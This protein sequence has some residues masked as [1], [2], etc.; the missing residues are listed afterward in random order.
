MQEQ[1]SKLKP[2]VEFVNVKN[3]ELVDEKM[4]MDDVVLTLNQQL[5]LAAQCMKTKTFWLL[6]SM[7]TLSICK[8]ACLRPSL[9]LAQFNDAN[10]YLKKR[11]SRSDSDFLVSCCSA[12]LLRG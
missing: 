2:K 3:P 10:S 7:Q 5:R 1:S 4:D 6:Y 9:P 11:I 8:S 12:R